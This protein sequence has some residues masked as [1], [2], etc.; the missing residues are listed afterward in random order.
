MGFCA[1]QIYFHCSKK[2]NPIYCDI[3]AF[4]RI[5]LAMFEARLYYIRRNQELPTLN[6][7]EVYDVP[8]RP[9]YLGVTA[10][11]NAYP[12]QI[13][14]VLKAMGPINEGNEY[15]VPALA[16]DQRTRHGNL[17][18]KSEKSNLFETARSGSCSCRPSNKPAGARD[19]PCA[20]SNPRSH[21]ADRPGH[22]CWTTP[23]K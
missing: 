2:R 22:T 9:E 15:F 8:Y 19:I 10:T 16:A 18:P 14:R 21:L 11:V 1:I 4:Y 6:F 23:M 13:G 12:D 17:I 3:Y 7:K 20:Q 5:N